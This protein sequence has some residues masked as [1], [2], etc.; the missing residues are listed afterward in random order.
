MK[1]KLLIKLLVITA[2]ALTGYV[3]L[4]LGM[5]YIGQRNEHEALISEIAGVRRAL[6]HIPEA[7]QDLEQQLAAAQASLAA[8][9]G[10][11]PG[12]IHSTEVIN[13]IL[14]LAENT[15]VNALP[16]V[17]QP[18]AVETVGGHS[19]GV[20]RLTVAIEGGFSQ[21]LNFIRKL[22]NGELKT[23]IVANLSVTRVA[24]QSE[25]EITPVTA[26]LSLA[27]YTRSPASD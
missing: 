5:G 13:A 18:W 25:K 24:G 26:S 12:K 17:T 21:L 8:A 27:V 20:L 4:N 1:G 6:V 2:V 16:L 3:Y 10:A 9:Q 7:P 22:E 23:L 19:Y 14:E 11:F 15:D